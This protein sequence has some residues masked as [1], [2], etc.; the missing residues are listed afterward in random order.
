M[1]NLIYGNGNSVF[2]PTFLIYGN[3]IHIYIF[4][5]SRIKVKRR[6][7]TLY[8]I[9]LQPSIYAASSGIRSQKIDVYRVLPCYLCKLFVRCFTDVSLFGT[10]CLEKSEKFRLS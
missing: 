6:G 7:V 3:K 9:R 4:F 5:F 10:L 8:T 1:K 2:L